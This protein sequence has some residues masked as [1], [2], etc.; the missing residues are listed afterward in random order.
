MMSAGA[1]MTKYRAMS[2]EDK[3][4]LHLVMVSKT[5]GPR[6]GLPLGMYLLEKEAYQDFPL[7]L[8]QHERTELDALIIR[9]HSKLKLPVLA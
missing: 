6:I 4:L 8:T 2:P 3:T 1:L 5:L 9:S 7:E